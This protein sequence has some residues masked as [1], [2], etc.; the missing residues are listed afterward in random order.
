M[1]TQTANKSKC[2]YTYDQRKILLLK[3][4]YQRDLKMFI[5]ML[6]DVPR[7]WT[8]TVIQEGARRELVVNVPAKK[9]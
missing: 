5:E 6:G 1:E 4:A 8:L 7:D 3:E 9:K 2:T